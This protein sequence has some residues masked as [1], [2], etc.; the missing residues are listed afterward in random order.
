MKRN[1]KKLTLKLAKKSRRLKKS[2]TRKVRKL[3]GG[4]IFKTMSYLTTRNSNDKNQ[5]PQASQRPPNLSTAKWA[6]YVKLAKELEGKKGIPTT[7]LTK[8]DK[9]KILMRANKLANDDKKRKTIFDK[10]VKDLLSLTML[11]ATPLAP[12]RPV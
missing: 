1:N 9:D 12:S 3:K 8:D 4:N 5:L 10:E 11:E 7:I 6:S 2:R